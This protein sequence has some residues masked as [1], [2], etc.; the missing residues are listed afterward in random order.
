MYYYFEESDSLDSPA[1]CFYYNADKNNFP[2]RPH[3]H[4]FMEIIYLVEGCAEMNSGNDRFILS[5]GDMIVFHPKAVHSIYA[6]NGEP[7]R[8]AVLKF[9]I[10]RLNMTPEYSPTFRSIFR[11]AE[12]KCMNIFFEADSTAASE[13]GEI[14]RRCISE[15]NSYSYGCDMVI[16][17]EIS[18]L[19][20]GIIRC[21]QEQGFSVDSNAYADD[22]RYDIYSITEYIDK[23]MGDGI[24]VTDIARECGMSY[25]YFAK[26]FLEVYGK[27]CKE[28][29]ESVRIMK[30]EEF[31]LYT[32]FDLSYIS[33]EMGFS[34]CSHMIK[35]FRRYKGITP[36]QF[37][38][39]HK[40]S[41]T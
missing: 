3:W 10:N 32:D 18:R 7:L 33:Q 4:Y 34:D 15:T 37:R 1:E 41:E 17:A 38:M 29:I 5:E 39:Q 28:Y 31:L 23:H 35:S 36:K 16:R 24:Q 27:T 13:A 22:M 21:W 9:D 20:I 8:Y 25:S 19:L 11:S 26:K 30:A 12:K 14:F 2:V 6:T 40:K